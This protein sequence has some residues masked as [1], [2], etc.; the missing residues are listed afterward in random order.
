MAQSSF[1]AVCVARG[2][3]LRH[4]NQHVFYWHPDPIIRAPIF[5]HDLMSVV[6]LLNKINADPLNAKVVPT[7]SG[8]EERYVGEDS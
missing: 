7:Y 6:E 4:S 8:K 3:I 2:E 5:T 1:A